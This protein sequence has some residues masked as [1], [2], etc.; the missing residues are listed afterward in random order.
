MADVL[1][2]IVLNATATQNASATAVRGAPT[3]QSA[4]ATQ[5]VSA[6]AVRG[7]PTTQSANATQS[8]SGIVFFDGNLGLDGYA[9]LPSLTISAYGDSSVLT[10]PALTLTASGEVG[11]NGEADPFLP[12]LTLS[13]SGLNGSLGALEKALP[14]L[15][16][17]A[18]NGNNMIADLPALT[19]S[20]IGEA[21]EYAT[22]NRVLPALTLSSSGFSEQI[23]TLAKALPV[24]TLEAAGESGIHGT[25][26]ARLAALALS[27]EGSTGIIGQAAVIL[28]VLSLDAAGHIDVIGE[29]AVTLPMLQLEATQPRS[30][31]AKTSGF[32][33]N[34]EVFG[35]SSYSNY[36]FE[37][38]AEFGGVIL[39]VNDSGIFAI[40]GDL[41]NTAAI[42]SVIKSGRDDLVTGEGQFGENIKEAVCAYIGYTA[43]GDLILT[44][45][46]DGKPPGEYRLVSTGETAIHSYKQKLGRGL[47]GR[48]WQYEI[49][50][51]AGANFE[52]E[53]FTL[54][55]KPIRRRA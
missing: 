19:L 35:L 9:Y 55:T 17:V 50:N 26:T 22:F 15:T 36:G 34:T 2:T 45:T 54:N 29:A 46:T 4:T 31:V 41:D 30:T 16:L 8:A 23:G 13:A 48:Y 6:V 42:A 53:T 52:I 33:L 43:T 14:A 39:G 40:G 27:A 32:A 44:V 10:L 11:I 47:Q 51:D 12:A 25:M 21:G 37:S 3:T 18:N 5:T 49:R 38:F 7:A 28:P 20:A 24:L 1:A